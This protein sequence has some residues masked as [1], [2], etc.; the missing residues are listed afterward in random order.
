ML[1][2]KISWRQTKKMDVQGFN[3]RKQDSLFL[4]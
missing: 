4:E 2:E 1:K 3:R